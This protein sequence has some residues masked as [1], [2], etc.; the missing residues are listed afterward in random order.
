M[1]PVR[2]V[3]TRL[4][5]TP[6]TPAAATQITSEPRPLTLDSA[7]KGVATVSPS[8]ERMSPR[9]ECKTGPTTKMAAR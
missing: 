9:I 1:S 6:S 8:G 3:L 7:R 2:T 5:T 4:A